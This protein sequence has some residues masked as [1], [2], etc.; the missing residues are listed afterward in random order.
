[1]EPY[2]AGHDS[3]IVNHH[4]DMSDR[5]VVQ[6]VVG[7]SSYT[8]QRVEVDGNEF[9]DNGGVNRVNGVDS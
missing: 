9:R 4:I 5:P 7:C 6:G 2:R 1:M 3:S 8:S